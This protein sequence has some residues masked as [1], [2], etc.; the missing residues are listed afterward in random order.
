MSEEIWE[1]QIIN[2][3]HGKIKRYTFF[4]PA[5]N[6]LGAWL[7]F[8]RIEDAN[9]DGL[10]HQRKLTFEFEHGKGFLWI[11]DADGN[12]RNPL[13]ERQWFYGELVRNGHSCMARFRFID[14]VSTGHEQGIRIFTHW[15]PGAWKSFPKTDRQGKLTDFNV[16]LNFGWSVN[17]NAYHWEPKPVTSASAEETKEVKKAPKTF[18]PGGQKESKPANMAAETPAETAPVKKPKIF[19]PKNKPTT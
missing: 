14:E 2:D 4:N 12:F 19:V 17:G 8:I 10:N 13:Y 5:T 6:G 3:Q 18:V 15:Q 1:K 11:T 7:E 9:V 16:D